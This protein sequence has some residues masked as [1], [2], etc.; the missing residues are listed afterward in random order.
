MTTARYPRQESIVAVVFVCLVAALAV[1]LPNFA[2][3][4]FGGA[5][6][7][8]S[9]ARETRMY[10]AAWTL[11]L[12]MAGSFL[13]RTAAVGVIGS[14]GGIRPLIAG[15][16][17]GGASTL[18]WDFGLLSQARVLIASESVLKA[19][20]LMWS[21]IIGGLIALWSRKPPLDVKA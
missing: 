20:T 8:S 12:A 2:F 3:A 14:D 6:G 1:E 17:V 4:Q 16:A 13:G 21:I 11:G 18:W 10:A 15:L 9:E 19:A 5:W 7:G